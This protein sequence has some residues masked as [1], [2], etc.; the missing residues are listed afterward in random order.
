[1]I[2]GLTSLILAGSPLLLSAQ[3]QNPGN[4]NLGNENFVFLTNLP[5]VS[6]PS[7]SDFGPYV[8]GIVKLLIGAAGVL[9]VIMIIIGGLQYMTT[10]AVSGKQEGKEKIWKALLGLLIAIASWLILY[11]INPNLISTSLNLQQAPTPPAPGNPLPQGPDPIDGNYAQCFHT[12]NACL[13]SQSQGGCPILSE[14]QPYND[15]HGSGYCYIPDL[16]NC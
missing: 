6:A 10:D 13:A 9:A 5:G 14:C 3:P 16:E 4:E 11:T 12:E 7:G 2:L 8:N 1:M 15:E